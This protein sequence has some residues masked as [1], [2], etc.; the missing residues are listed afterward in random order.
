MEVISFCFGQLYISDNDMG[1][2]GQEWE[3][4]VV[5]DDQFISDEYVE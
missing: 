2:I 1:E 5:E 4:F 3:V